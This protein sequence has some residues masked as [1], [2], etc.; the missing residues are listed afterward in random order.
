MNKLIAT[1]M[2]TLMTINLSASPGLCDTGGESINM[3]AS[4]A[5]WF[6]LIIISY[7]LWRYIAE[8]K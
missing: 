2:F 7:G 3:T 5:M 1:V 6:V 8:D 4:Y